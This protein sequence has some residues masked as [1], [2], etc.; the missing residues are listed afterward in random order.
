MAD[1]PTET[2]GVCNPPCPL[3]I[4]TAMQTAG[5]CQHRDTGQQPAAAGVVERLEIEMAEHTSWLQNGMPTGDNLWSIDL[6]IRAR[7]ELLQLQAKVTAADKL[8][9]RCT[10]QFAE[11]IEICGPCDHRVNICI[12]HITKLRED[13]AAYRNPQDAALQGA[14]R[15]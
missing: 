1:S 8:L 6:L 5:L 9:D 11:D 3:H 14:A 12:C 2:A 15:G 4:C 13:I 7:K 10:A